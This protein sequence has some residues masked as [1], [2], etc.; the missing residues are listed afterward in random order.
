MIFFKYPIYHHSLM[1]LVSVTVQAYFG[2]FQREMRLFVLRTLILR[3]YSIQL[4]I[5]CNGVDPL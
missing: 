5:M 3:I 4:F 1:I 2:G